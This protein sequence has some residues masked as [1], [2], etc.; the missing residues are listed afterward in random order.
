MK[1]NVV[2][3]SCR[4]APCK[5]NKKSLKQFIFSLLI[6]VICFA[7]LF[8]AACNNNNGGEKSELQ[9]RRES[10]IAYIT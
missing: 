7:T 4:K 2:N 3:R 6:A 10:V 5:T 8:F 1:N 9:K